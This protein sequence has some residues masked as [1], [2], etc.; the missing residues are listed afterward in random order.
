MRFSVLASGSSGNAIYVEADKKGIL[1]DSGLSCKE[2]LRRL[3][4]LNVDPDRVQ[5]LVITHEHTDHVKGAGP[6]ARR[7]DL[8]V[9]LNRSTYR[10]CAKTLGD[11]PKLV[12][13]KT[14]QALT[15]GN[16]VVETFSKCHDA[17]DPMG[18]VVAFDGLR[19]GLMT[20]LGRSTRLVENRLK[21]CRA[22][23]LEFNHDLDLL[24]E[25]PYPLYL[26]RRIRGPEGHLSNGQAGE[27]IQAL[28]HDELDV[29]V[30][31]HISRENNRPEIA[32]QEALQVLA[33]CGLEKSRVELSLQDTPM[34]LEE[35]D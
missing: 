28:A 34:P 30:P 1:I 32:Y 7:L 14:G 15:I 9:F 4:I 23:V 13:I 12:S 3:E 29:V 2:L 17:A 20:D 35:M 16:L 24:E 25:G 6:V 33:S 5:G 10:K 8:P 27:I 19:I 22:L 31:A 11:I 18:I 26:K 21:G